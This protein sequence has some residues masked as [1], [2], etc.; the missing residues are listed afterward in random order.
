MSAGLNQRV[1][2]CPR[3]S[4]LLLLLNRIKRTWMSSHSMMATLL[5]LLLKSSPIALIAESEDEI[6]FARSQISYSSTDAVSEKDA[7]TTNI[8]DDVA[9]VKA[10]NSST[11]VVTGDTGPFKVGSVVHLAS[12]GGKRVVAYPYSKK[13]AKELGWI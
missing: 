4:P 1:T 6:T 10:S 2:S 8:D 5:Q 12:E 7:S 13:L 9:S 3:A 11:M